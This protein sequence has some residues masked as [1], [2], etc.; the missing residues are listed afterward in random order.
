MTAMPDQCS[1]TEGGDRCTKGEGHAPAGHVMTGTYNPADPGHTHR[2]PY[3]GE[4]ADGARRSANIDLSEADTLP[5]GPHDPFWTPATEQRRNELIASADRW[6]AQAADLEAA[7][8]LPV[9]GSGPQ[10]EE[11]EP[12]RSEAPWV[13]PGTVEASLTINPRPSAT[14]S[15]EL[16]A[17]YARLL[18]QLAVQAGGAQNIDRGSGFEV[19]LTVKGWKHP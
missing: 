2:V 18:D 3:V 1:Y 12:L 13:P 17:A 5:T 10:Y 11:G 9:A 7:A 4:G 15:A 8:V 14:A 19:T 16:G 6:Q